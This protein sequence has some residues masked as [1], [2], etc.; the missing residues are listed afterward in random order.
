MVS[1]CFVCCPGD[2]V[3]YSAIGL[4][5][6]QQNTMPTGQAFQANIGSQPGNTPLVAAAGM[7]LSQ[8]NDITQ[9]QILKHG[10]IISSDCFHRFR[11]QCDRPD[12]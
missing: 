10:G 3:F 7:G 9:L 11:I 1:I 12:L 2:K 8:P 4:T 6:R 5:S